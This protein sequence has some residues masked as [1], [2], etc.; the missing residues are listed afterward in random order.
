[1]GSKFIIKKMEYEDIPKI[2]S[3]LKEPYMLER[4]DY[5]SNYF[6]RCLIEMNNSERVSFVAFLDN[7]VVGYV[8]IIFKSDY[9]YFQESNIPEINDLYVVPSVRKNGVGKELIS[10]CE[11]YATEHNF[12]KIGLGV[13]LYRGYASAQRLYVK[14]GYLPDG[15][16]LMYYN[17]EVEPGKQVLVD[18]ELLLYLYK[19][20]FYINR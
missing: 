1:M 16:G 2:L 12:E 7:E 3:V 14:N 19:E 17:K 10:C 15:N 5:Y 11:A 8:H 6:N 9:P 18:D 13:G 20:L 4:G